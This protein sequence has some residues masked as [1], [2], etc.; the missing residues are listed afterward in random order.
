MSRLLS[1]SLLVVVCTA[2]FVRA[3]DAKQMEGTWKAV[4]GELGGKPYPDQML[5]NLKLV[6]A[7]GK[8]VVTVREPQGEQ[9]DEGTLTLDPAKT[10]HEM[11][12]VGIKGPNQG[13]TT[14]AIY[15]LT[16]DT[17][18]ICYD[19]SRKAHP[20]EFKSEPATKLFL[21]EYQRQKPE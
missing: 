14:P 11:T 21:V 7:D 1:C 2:S 13:R 17:L 20:K 19:L 16:D 4:K 9:T 8:Y 15:E 12:I 3:D 10:P 5:K 6:I 18:R